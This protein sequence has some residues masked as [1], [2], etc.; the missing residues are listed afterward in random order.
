MLDR[1]TIN[2]TILPLAEIGKGVR[3]QGERDY[4]PFNLYDFYKI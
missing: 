1:L 2:L 3:V 4:F